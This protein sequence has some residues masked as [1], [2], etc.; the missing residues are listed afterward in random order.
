ML[1]KENSTNQQFTISPRVSDHNIT[2]LARSTG[3]ASQQ[4]L[5]Q[6][7]QLAVDIPNIIHIAS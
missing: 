3:V 1:V 7:H 5:T 2:Q 6:I 4:N